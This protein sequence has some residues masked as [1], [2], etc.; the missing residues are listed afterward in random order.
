M[1]IDAVMLAAFGLLT[2]HEAHGPR[3]M[4][5]EKASLTLFV[6]GRNSSFKKS[7]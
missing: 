5:K 2:L 6:V 7:S 1:E 4:Y 3:S